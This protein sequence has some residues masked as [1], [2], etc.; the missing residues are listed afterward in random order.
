MQELNEWNNMKPYISLPI[1][2]LFL[3][4]SIFFRK[5]QPKDMWVSQAWMLYVEH[6]AKNLVCIN[7]TAALSECLLFNIKCT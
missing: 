4:L 5:D 6:Y 7:P 2:Q 3:W 1:G